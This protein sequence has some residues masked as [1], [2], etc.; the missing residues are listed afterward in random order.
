MTK[1][2]KSGKPPAGP[3]TARSAKAAYE[4]AKK[5]VWVK[6]REF[7]EQESKKK[8]GHSVSLLEKLGS[9]TRKGEYR[10]YGF[11]YIKKTSS[12]KRVYN[13]TQAELGRRLQRLGRGCDSPG[14]TAGSPGHGRTYQLTY[15]RPMTDGSRRQNFLWSA[16]MPYPHQAHHIVPDQ[17]FDLAFTE[18]QRKILR[19]VPYDLNH[20]ENII[21]LPKEP[22]NSTVHRLVTHDGSHPI[23]T[24]L[25][26]SDMRSVKGQLTEAVCEE[27]KPPPISV[28]DD[29]IALQSDYWKYIV[30]WGKANCTDKINEAADKELQRR[31]AETLKSKYSPK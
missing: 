26:V 15:I 9:Y 23:Y 6:N 4:K 25:V 20:G 8:K 31:M 22:K 3:Q 17:T 14:I 21:L 19:M 27:A 28:L 7:F 29:L 24:E 2:A 16:G 30:D 5:D 10:A 11:H 18:R 13:A 12:R 1:K